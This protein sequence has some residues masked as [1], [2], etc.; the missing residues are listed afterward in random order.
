MPYRTLCDVLEEMRQCSKTGNYSYLPGLIEEAQTLGNRMEAR[1]WEQKDISRLRD[2]IKEL[3][4]KRTKLQ[5]K[6]KELGGKSDEPSF[7]YE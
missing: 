7:D 2:E 1:L 5:K 4:A 3:K 6:I